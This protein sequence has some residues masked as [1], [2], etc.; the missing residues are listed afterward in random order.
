M[1]ISQCIIDDNESDNARLSSTRRNQL[2]TKPGSAR[3]GL[4]DSAQNA[5][6]NLTHSLGLDYGFS[7]LLGPSSPSM[8]S[9]LLDHSKSPVPRLSKPEDLEADPWTMLIV[10]GLDPD[11][12]GFNLRDLVSLDIRKQRLHAKVFTIGALYQFRCVKMDVT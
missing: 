9:L 7:Q 11:Q 5:Y 4:K 6:I 1:I 2:T 3:E 8:D 10:E 12:T